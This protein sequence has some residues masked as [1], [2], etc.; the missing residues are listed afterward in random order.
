[1]K[2]IAMVLA[3]LL[4]LESSFFKGARAEPTGENAAIAAPAS[5]PQTEEK[6]DQGRTIWPWVTVAS[7]GGGFILTTLVIIGVVALLFTVGSPVGSS[8][9][10]RSSNGSGGGGQSPVPAITLTR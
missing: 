10:D 1:M 4:L 9:G 5:N 8:H 3:A 6:P 2:W 7:L